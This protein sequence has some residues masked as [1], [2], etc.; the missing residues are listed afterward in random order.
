MRQV[1]HNQCALAEPVRRRSALQGSAGFSLVE[2]MIAMLLGLL[3]VGAL[4]QIYVG[5]RDVNRIIANAVTLNENGRFAMELFTRDIR[6]AGYFS[7]GG[8]KSKVAHALRAETFWLRL[9]GITGFDG[10]GDAQSPDTLPSAF[11]TLPAPLAG[12]DVLVVR[13]ADVRRGRIVR[14]GEMDIGNKRFVFASRHPFALGQVLIAN[15]AACDQ[16]SVF[17]VV[18]SINSGSFIVSYDKNATTVSPG[19]CSNHL[20]GDYSCAD[21]D[22]TLRERDPADRF[23]NAQ[24]T[25]LTARA[26]FVANLPSSECTPTAASCAALAQCPTLYT[27]GADVTGAVPVLRD[28]TDLEISYGIDSAVNENVPG[29]GDASVDFY[30]D[31]TEVMAQGR[32]HQVISIKVDLSITNADCVQVDF[33]TTTALRNS[34]T[35]NLLAY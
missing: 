25:P 9:E 24:L 7:C 16:T 11:D 35:G 27:A 26:Y 1:R 2:L 5:S 22:R 28:V 33:V 6:L 18:S 17:Q 3:V 20:A 31:A 21:A 13:Y 23:V 29:S 19:N 14:S 30:L 10:G 32:W 15:D 12:T 34:P 4:G 8:A